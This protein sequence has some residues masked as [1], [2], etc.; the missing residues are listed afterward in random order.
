MDRKSQQLGGIF[1]VLAGLTAIVGSVLH[2]TQPQTLDALADLG[3]LWTASHV[4][5]GIAGTLF[6]VSAIHLARDFQRSAGEG[7]ALAGSG[8]L[9][10]GGVAVLVIGALETAGFSRLLAAQE[11]GSGVAAEHAFLALG[12]VMQSLVTAAGFLFPMATTAFALAMLRDRSWPSWLAWLGVVI[13]VASLALNVFGIPLGPVQ[14]VLNSYLG[15]GWFVV[16]GVL[17][18]GRARVAVWATRRQ[19]ERPR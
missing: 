12:S 19:A 4:A 6:L 17:F 13:G 9:I 10:L 8:V 11:A 16:V 15:S 5:I 14:E 1:I 3:A 2:P 18:M 7:W